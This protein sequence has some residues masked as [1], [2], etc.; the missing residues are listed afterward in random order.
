M[1]IFFVHNTKHL[2][3]IGCQMTSRG[4]EILLK[5]HQ[6]E[7]FFA[8]SVFKINQR[9]ISSRR[10]KP[11]TKSVSRPSR[12]YFNFVKRYILRNKR[13]ILSA[14]DSCDLVIINGEGSIH[15]NS[16]TS[17]ILLAIASIAKDR[18]KTVHL[19]NATLQALTPTQIEIL[20]K[21]DRIVVREVYSRHYLA[22]NEIDSVLG[23]DASWIFLNHNFRAAFQKRKIKKGIERRILL[24][25]GVRGEISE[26]L[27][28]R[29]SSGNKK[30]DYLAIDPLD[31][32]KYELL[33][34]KINFQKA[35]AGDSFLK[36][37]DALTKNYDLVVSG[38]HHIAIAALFFGLPLIPVATNTYKIEATLASLK[39]I[40]A[41]L[42]S[43]QK[44]V[45]CSKREIGR[46]IKLAHE[47]FRRY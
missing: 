14:I 5:G 1:R 16:L 2:A 6:V 22:G 31:L 32:K 4:I 41:S 29:L 33:K 27:L 18:H 15:H 20:K 7:N 45:V 30:V 37:A 13:N 25:P 3:N 19:I 46:A 10:L 34:S 23:A 40:H 42:D 26:N 47:N 28:N 24:T 35:I 36:K 8:E 43:V 9:L 21:L 11:F 38:R 39:G 12:A 17:I 44:G